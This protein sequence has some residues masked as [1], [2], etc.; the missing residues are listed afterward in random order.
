MENQGRSP[1][2]QENNEK[3]AAVSVSLFIIV[4]TIILFIKCI[5]SL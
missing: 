4:L 2:Q 3:L 5:E 1:R